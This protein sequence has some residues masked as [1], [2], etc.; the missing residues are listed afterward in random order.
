MN[1]Q[2]V[3]NLI[4]SMD[5]SAFSCPNCGLVHDANDTEIAEHV[6]SYHGEE[7]HEFSC[8]ECGA[9]FFVHETV[10]RSFEATMCGVVS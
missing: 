6:I 3:L 5:D 7:P 4:A 9:D 10:R 1:I 2:K 8:G